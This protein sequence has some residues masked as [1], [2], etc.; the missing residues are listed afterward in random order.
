MVNLRNFLIRQSHLTHKI[1]VKGGGCFQ[2]LQIA[3]NQEEA[4]YRGRIALDLGIDNAGIH[5]GGEGFAIY[6]RSQLLIN[7]FVCT[8]NDL[9][10]NIV[11]SCGLYVSSKYWQDFFGGGFAFCVK[12]VRLSLLRQWHTRGKRVC[13]A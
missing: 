2:Y 3:C 4:I 6:K 5:I 11:A 10:N 13:F 9:A 12:S 7:F 1:S 8:R